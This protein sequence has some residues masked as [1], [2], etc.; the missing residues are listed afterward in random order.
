MCPLINNK[1]STVARIALLCTLPPP[2]P[3]ILCMYR[4][5]IW[6]NP[7]CVFETRYVFLML[8]EFDASDVG[9]WMG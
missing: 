1:H 4:Y 3:S 9:L 2:S 6:H 7:Q 5:I 8:N